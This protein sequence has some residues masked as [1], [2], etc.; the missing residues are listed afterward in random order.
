MQRQ[1]LTTARNTEPCKADEL[2]LHYLATKL[3]ISQPIWRRLLKS[4]YSKW[5]IHFVLT[6]N[7]K[8][9]R[10]TF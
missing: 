10:N 7:F 9:I 6:L 1:N 5:S 8:N 4:F 2:S 3:I